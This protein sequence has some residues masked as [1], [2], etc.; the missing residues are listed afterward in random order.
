MPAV[1]PV[2]PARRNWLRGH[3]RLVM[4]HGPGNFTVLPGRQGCISGA[5]SSC[6]R[7]GARL[8]SSI[9]NP[10]PPKTA[11]CH[12]PSAICHRFQIP[13][14]TQKSRY[15]KNVADLANPLRRSAAVS[16]AAYRQ[17]WPGGTSHTPPFRQPRARKLRRHLAWPRAAAEAAALR[18]QLVQSPFTSDFGFNL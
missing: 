17:A 8:P 1:E 2:L 7:T 14:K 13:L 15:I 12:L 6:A 10:R 18:R 3:Q 9:L 11:I 16:A 4:R 5:M